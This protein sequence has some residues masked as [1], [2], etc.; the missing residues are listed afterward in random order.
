VVPVS[1]LKSFYSGS[2]FGSG[3]G[4]GSSSGSGCRQCLAVFQQQQNL[5]NIAF[6]MSE[7]ALFQ[8]V[9]FHF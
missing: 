2:S 8:E 7:G 6:S 9:G 3:F 5:Q 1:T 4:S